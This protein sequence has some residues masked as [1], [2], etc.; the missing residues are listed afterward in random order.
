MITNHSGYAKYTLNGVETTSDNFQMYFAE[1][2][3]VV[4]EA[5]STVYLHSIIIK[6]NQEAPEAPTLESLVVEGETTTFEVGEEFT[7]ADLVV[8]AEY[9]DF[10]LLPVTEYT[11][12]L[13]G[14]INVAGEYDAVVTYQGKTYTYKVKYIA[15][16]VDP[17]LVTKSM[18][19]DTTECKDKFEKSTGQWGYLNIDATNG[20]FA[21]NGSG[22]VQFNTGTIITIKVAEGAQVEVSTY[23]DAEICDIYV[24]DGIATIEATA[25]GYIRYIT[26]TI[27]VIYSE[28][29][30]I[31]LSAT[32]ANIQGSTGVYEGLEVDATNGKFADNNGG[33][34]QVNTGTIIKLNVAEGAQV[35]V[36]AYS[37]ADSFEVS[38]ENG[39][40]TITA[41][42]NDYLKAITINYPVIYDENTTIDL[43]ATGANIQGSTGVYEGLEVDA[44]NGK[45]AD[46]NGGWVQVN[47]G[48]II[49]LNVAENAK[50]SV[51]AYSS[52]DSFEVSI[53]NGVA[54]ITAVANDYL[55]AISVSYPVVYSNTLI[56]LSATGANIQGSTGVYE[57]LEIDATNGKFADNNGGWV[58]VNTGTIIKLNVAAGSIV[59]VT[60]YSSADSFTI[61]VVDG[62]ATITAV[63]N[64][65]LKEIKVA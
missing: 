51:T 38:I 8:K 21:N 22:W 3:T 37:S 61:E 20:K 10:S 6:P 16:G 63:A 4:F 1:D 34:V 39:V 52:A 13:V 12:E 9:S 27:P 25:N 57:G 2:T 36:T 28:N 50:V 64:D 53:E 7:Y 58:Q 59:T 11:V 26:I 29:T 14:D 65:Y 32:G 18:V 30:T 5:Y 46:N 47:T 19:I 23:Q 17:T 62:V 33:W 31:D 56:D 41:V 35:S 40:A 24:A 54:T 15:A 43:S 44:T 45:F 55:K 48:T 60:A 42:A 49:K